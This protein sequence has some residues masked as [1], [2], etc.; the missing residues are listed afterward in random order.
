MNT[1]FVLRKAPRATLKRTNDQ[2]MLT[3]NLHLISLS[4]SELR[5]N[6]LT[7]LKGVTAVTSVEKSGR[8]SF[9]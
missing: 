3:T 5:T 8:C 9:W 1:H 7:L 4:Y 6:W 2:R